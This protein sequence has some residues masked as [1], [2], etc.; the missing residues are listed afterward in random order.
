MTHI[1][2]Y[3][4]TEKDGLVCRFLSAALPVA[5][6]L[7][8]TAGQPVA[9]H[10]ADSTEALRTLGPDGRMQVPEEAAAMVGGSPARGGS[11]GS[12]GAAGSVEF[13]ARLG[14]L[15]F[16][17]DPAVNRGQLRCGVQPVMR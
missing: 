8:P 14:K 15:G 4:E 6:A 12:G 2:G 11:G 16:G 7:A 17:A 10:W 1:T 13:W 3:P 9:V 5:R